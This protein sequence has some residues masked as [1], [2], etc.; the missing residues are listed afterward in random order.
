[1]PKDTFDLPERSLSSMAEIPWNLVNYGVRQFAKFNFLCLCRILSA[2]SVVWLTLKGPV[3]LE[4][5][6]G[7]YVVMVKLTDYV[8]TMPW[9]LF[10]LLPSLPHLPL[11]SPLP[12]LP[13]LY[14]LHTFINYHSYLTYNS[15]LYCHLQ[16]LLPL[17]LYSYLLY[18]CY[19]SYFRYHSYLYYHL[20]LLYST[21]LTIFTSTSLPILT[22][23][24]TVTSLIHTVFNI[25]LPWWL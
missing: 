21:T 22:F 1:M 5:K 19:H 8:I 17:L 14:H 4:N 13:L 23:A 3:K 12:V 18:L 24:T 11:L 2:E 15:Y 16:P 6:M 20:Y 9:T 25:L 7:G 10:L